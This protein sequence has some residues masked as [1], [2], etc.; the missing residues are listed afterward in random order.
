MVLIDLDVFTLTAADKL[1]SLASG[2]TGLTTGAQTITGK[3]TFTSKPVLPA[4]EPQNNEAVSRSRVDT[5]ISEAI[6]SFG[7]TDLYNSETGF[8]SRAFDNINNYDALGITVRITGTNT[9]I[10][11]S[12]YVL[13]SDIGV[14]P[15]TTMLGTQVG[16]VR[17]ANSVTISASNASI[18][19][20]IIRV[21]G[22]NY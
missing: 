7:T 3:K 19:N 12:V 22:I 5:L 4:T 14:A 10:L 11:D 17:N 9:T 6:N 8:D 21:R 2:S 13:T 16:I 15:R 20:K 18:N 1:N